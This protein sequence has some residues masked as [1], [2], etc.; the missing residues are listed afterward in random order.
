MFSILKLRRKKVESKKKRKE[1]K[2]K[3]ERKKHGHNEEEVK[4]KRCSVDDGRHNDDRSMNCEGEKD[5]KRGRKHEISGL[6]NSTLSVEPG[7]HTIP[8]NVLDHSEKYAFGKEKFSSCPSQVLGTN[9]PHKN[10][11][12]ETELEYRKLVVNW[13]PP[14]LQLVQTDF[15]DEEWFS[16]KNLLRSTE[17]TQAKQDSNV[18]CSYQGIQPYAQF[19]PNANIYALP[20]TVPF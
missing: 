19:L 8:V 6:E 9:N 11:M 20:Y 13:V 18:T 4:K 10:D 16:R 7:Q 12:L 1:K 3:K 14:P 17:R 15:E 5:R 2:R